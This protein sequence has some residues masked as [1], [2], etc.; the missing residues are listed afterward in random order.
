MSQAIGNVRELIIIYVAA[1]WYDAKLTVDFLLFNP[2]TCN[3]LKNYRLL[4]GGCSILFLIAI[5][6]FQQRKLVINI[7]HSFASFPPSMGN[8]GTRPITCLVNTRLPNH[9]TADF[10]ILAS[11]SVYAH[12]V[13]RGRV[14]SSSW[15]VCS[16]YCKRPHGQ[17]QAGLS[18]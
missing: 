4:N 12:M 16:A 13:P 10:H 1:T 15:K 11:P 17:T 7:L 9:L 3:G 14:R 6:L 18:S 8:Y 2:Q 5:C